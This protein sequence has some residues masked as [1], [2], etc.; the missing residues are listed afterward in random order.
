MSSVDSRSQV[1]KRLMDINN[2]REHTNNIR[3]MQK[4]FREI[5][6]RKCSCNIKSAFIK[7]KKLFIPQK[8]METTHN[9]SVFRNS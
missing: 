7:L 5:D 8:S 6:I 9:F 4:T 1:N 3:A 2:F